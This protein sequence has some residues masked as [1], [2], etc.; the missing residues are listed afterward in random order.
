MKILNRKQFLALPG[1]VLFSK[2]EPY[3]FESFAI[4]GETW[5]N[6]FL[7]Q[8]IVDSVAANST[9]K[10]AEI[11]DDAQETGDSIAMDF[12]CLDRDGCFDKDQLFAVWEEKDV[13][14]LIDRLKQL[15]PAE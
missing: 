9:E 6:D 1:Q 7:V 4:K 11:L 14:Q 12:D 15:L 8:Y 10:F 13:R 3:V 5:G 2:Y